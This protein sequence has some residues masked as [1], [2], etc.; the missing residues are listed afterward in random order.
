MDYKMKYCVIWYPNGVPFFME[1]FKDLENPSD[2][3][4]TPSL[5]NTEDEAERI[6]WQCPISN[7]WP[8]VIVELP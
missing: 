8:F 6:A 2:S 4:V 3:D 5:F 7:Q 1:Q